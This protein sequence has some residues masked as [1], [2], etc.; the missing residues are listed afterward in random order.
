MKFLLR[1]SASMQ[2][3]LD[4]GRCG[5]AQETETRLGSNQNKSKHLQLRPRQTCRGLTRVSPCYSLHM[6]WFVKRLTTLGNG[7][8]ICGWR[9][10]ILGWRLRRIQFL[11]GIF[12]VRAMITL[13]GC[14][15]ARL[16]L[17]TRRN[18]SPVHVSVVPKIA[19]RLLHVPC[20][21]PWA[22]C[23]HRIKKSFRRPRT[24]S[25]QQP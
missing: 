24:R 22:I 2:V 4:Y 17:L 1:S 12:A 16:N 23:R 14:K 25:V 6:V 15:S 21:L 7:V 19:E 11:L 3:S 13:C 5:R 10:R 8:R 18:Y 20:K 9:L